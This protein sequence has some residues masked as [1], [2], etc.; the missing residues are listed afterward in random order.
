MG[1][2]SMVCQIL[3]SCFLDLFTGISVHINMNTARAYI[4]YGP[5]K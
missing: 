3:V 1:K 4:V 2:Y 5:G